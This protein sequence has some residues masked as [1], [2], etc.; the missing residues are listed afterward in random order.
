MAMVTAARAG[1]WARVRTLYT[2]FLPLIVFEQQ[3]GVAVRK[4]IFRLRGV[5]RISQARHPGTNVPPAT[6]EQLRAL[7]EQV[8]PGEDITKPIQ[9]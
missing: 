2:R 5:I 1:N 9:V 3:P 4:E 8:L 6:A 7:I